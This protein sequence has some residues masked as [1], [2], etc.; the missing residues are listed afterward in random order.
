MKACPVRLRFAGWT[1]VLVGF[2][3]L[4]YSGF[5]LRNLYDEQIEAVDLDLDADGRRLTGLNTLP[6]VQA[7]AIED[8]RYAAWRGFALFDEFGRLVHRNPRFP[9]AFARAAL[10]QT[11]FQTVRDENGRWRIG[12]FAAPGGT[13]VV[14]YDLEEVREIMQDLMVAYSLSLPVVILI[15]AAGGW[16][17]SGRALQPIRELTS[18]VTRI[19]AARLDQRVPVPPASDEIQRLSLVLNSMLGRLERSFEQAQR[20]AADASHELRT[21]LTIMRG[22]I[23]R[24]MQAPEIKSGHQ[25]VLVSVQEEIGRLQHI[26]DNLLLLARFDSGRVLLDA[27]FVDFTSLVQD[28]CEDAELLGADR[29]IRIERSLADGIFAQGD[30]AHLRR[31]VLNLLDNAVKFNFPGGLVNCSLTGDDGA[32]TL[33]IANTGPGIAVDLRPRLFERFFRADPSRSHAGK[34]YGL[35]LSLSREIARAHGGDLRWM[36]GSDEGWTEFVLSLPAAP[37]KSPSVS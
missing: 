8:E 2:V 1:A 26:T 9:E 30:P 33:R 15:A 13:L 29:N 25:E 24:L 5:T 3:L 4:V 21:P 11:K 10:T 37:G 34:G 17:V 16:W 20:F 31:V 7:A 36:E 12:A 19:E 18:A 22:E 23:D 27:K 6:Q 35:G 14:A 28:A 32:A